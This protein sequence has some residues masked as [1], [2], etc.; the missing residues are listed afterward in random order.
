MELT[1]NHHHLAIYELDLFETYSDWPHQ[2]TRVPWGWVFSDSC[3]MTWN[4]VF[5]PYNDEYL[6][7]D[8]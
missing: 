4:S 6:H 3:S 8:K 1:K 7:G 2:A 5:I